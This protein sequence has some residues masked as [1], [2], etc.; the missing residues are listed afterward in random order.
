MPTLI[1]I[2]SCLGKGSTGRITEAIG[3]IMKKQGWDCYVVHGARYLGKTQLNSIQV[4]SENQE[5]LHALGSMLF[6]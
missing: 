1:Q 5:Y 2:D 3:G 6:D 4:V